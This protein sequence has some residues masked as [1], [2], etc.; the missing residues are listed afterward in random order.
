MYFGIF[1]R[2]HLED[3]KYS[4]LDFKRGGP[5]CSQREPGKAILDYFG[6]LLGS[7]GLLWLLLGPP[8]L[9]ATVPV[10]KGNEKI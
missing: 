3:A 5:R 9:R 10:S 4:N 6:G 7:P 2:S 1:S 8:V